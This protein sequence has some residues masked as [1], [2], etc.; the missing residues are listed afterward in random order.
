MHKHDVVLEKVVVELN[1]KDF[2]VDR[3]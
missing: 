1:A 3:E 2:V